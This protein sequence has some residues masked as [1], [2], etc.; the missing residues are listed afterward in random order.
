MSGMI[1]SILQNADKREISDLFLAAGKK[2]A[3]RIHGQVVPQEDLASV[4]AEELD[5]F[6]S[7][8]LSPGN[9]KFY[10]QK[11]SADASGTLPS[12]ERFRLNF[13]TTS[14]GPAAAIRM[15]HS[16]RNLSFRTLELPAPVEALAKEPRGLI[17]VTGTTGSGKSTTM[18]AIINEIN[19]TKK[20]HIL[21]LEDP[22]EYLHQ[23]ILSRISQREIDS[24]TTGFGEA[25]RGAMRENPDVIVIGEMRDLETVSAAVNAALTGHLVI[26]TLHTSDTIQSVERILNLYPAHLRGQ[27]AIDLSMALVA[28]VSQRLI[29]RKNSEKMIPAVELLLGTPTVRKAIA[30]TNY[31]NLEDALRRG[32][33]AGMA[34]FNRSIFQLYKA[35][36]ITLEDARLTSSNPDEFNL[37]IKGM[38]NGV[39]SFRSQYGDGSETGDDSFVDMRLL[40]QIAMDNKASDLH[41]TVNSRPMLRLNG[42]LRPV[43]LPVLT[44][45]DIQHLLYSVIT[46]RQRVELEEKRELDLALSIRLNSFDAQ[47]ARF[48]VNG[49]FQRGSLGVVARVV[50]TSIPSP[51]AL[52]LPPVLLDLINKRQGLILVTG[53]TGSG[54]STTL[55]SLL[56]QINRT[57]NGKIITI[58]DPIEYVHFNKQSIVEQREL[59][60]DTLSFSSALKYA[61]RQDPDVIMVGEMRD[62]E[63]M[64]SAITA[65]ETGHLVFATVHTNSA[66]QTIDRIVDSFPSHQQNQIRQQLASVV[67]GVISQRL[68]QTIDRPGRVAA[69]EVMV[70]TPPVQS[71]IRE[72]KTFQ[73][74]SV[75]E[76]S[77]KDGMITLEK[78]LENLYNQGRI[79]YEST[80]MF[81]PDYQ[82]TQSF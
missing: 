55:A 40:L 67:L 36:Q 28:V 68:L 13:Y 37:L 24:H 16:S 20:K 1:E 56:D 30:E 4:P 61:L 77:Y 35:D 51:E 60:S 49:F 72:G 58:E 31:S 73:L 43:D 74:Q 11:G 80:R 10:Q 79:S 25:M 39:E 21:T 53:P 17:L 22:I 3:L 64:A 19:R 14:S 47:M 69:F 52:S 27:A 62:T 7:R 38:E 63:T 59:H 26:A 15:I 65:A 50:N 32:S 34:T 54:K 41:L 33:G 6:R 5:K 82:V 8:M 76:T 46:P 18:A 23:D 12:G 29:P 57:R 81:R 9:E 70:G 75:I 44:G 78:Y 2:P 71:L 42:E 48:R 66:P 45:E